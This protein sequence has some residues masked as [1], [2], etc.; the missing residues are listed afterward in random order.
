MPES[1]TVPGGM[2]ASIEIALGAFLIGFARTF[3][4]VSVFAPFLWAGCAKGVLRFAVATAFA[5]PV[6]LPVYE[7]GPV[8]PSEGTIGVWTLLM[9]KEALVGLVL[10][11]LMSAPFWAAQLAGAALSMIRTETSDGPPE[12]GDTPLTRVMML[13]MICA[14]AFGGGLHRAAEVFYVAFEIWP[15][16]TVIPDAL[17]VDKAALV[18]LAA[19]MLAFSISI[20][21]PFLIVV[22]LSEIGIAFSTRFMKRLQINGM[23]LD[24]RTLLILGMLVLSTGMLVERA[25]QAIDVTFDSIVVILRASV[26][27]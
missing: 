13:F 8:V 23:A 21:A 6:M 5:L 9:L 24:I 4:F 20:L 14:F 16:G 17:V 11:L 25:G 10:G 2:F 27:R 12:I 3:T 1:L 18:A 7:A 22:T 15:P 26:A 19:A